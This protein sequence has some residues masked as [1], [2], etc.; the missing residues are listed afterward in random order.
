MPTQ[1]ATCV[2]V[3]NDGA[4]DLLK[5]MQIPWDVPEG[6]THIAFLDDG[7]ACFLSDEK[8]VPGFMPH[9]GFFSY[10]QDVLIEYEE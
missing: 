7:D 3:L 9:F 5:K 1:L 4:I 6:A 8:I 10:Y 2:I